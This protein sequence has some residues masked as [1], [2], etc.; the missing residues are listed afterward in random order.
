MLAMSVVES[1][2]SKIETKVFQAFYYVM[3]I[4]L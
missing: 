4:D 2:H 1:L 3:K